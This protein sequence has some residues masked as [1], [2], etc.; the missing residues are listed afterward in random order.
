MR[1]PVESSTS[2]RGR[3]S[4]PNWVAL[5]I[6]VGL[7]LSAGAIGA[8]CS[9]AAHMGA[10]GWYAALT[11]PAWAPPNGWF[12]PVWA[13][14]YVLMGTAAWLIWRERY[15]RKRGAALT[16]YAVQL[17]LNALWAPLFFGLKNIGAGLFVAVALWVAV[18]WT[19]REFVTVR[20]LAAWLLAPYVIWVS[21][22]MSLNLSIWRLNP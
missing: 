17:A 5:A 15:H 12:G 21:I 20:A 9:R 3:N 14:L 1:I 18:I 10:G 16:A 4:R 13:V 8:L 6:F 22:A 2:Y 7:A 19:I 11:K